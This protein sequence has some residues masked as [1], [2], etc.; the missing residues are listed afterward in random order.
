MT[1]DIRESNLNRQVV[2][3]GRSILPFL[4]IVT[5]Q[6]SALVEN[7]S[8]IRIVFLPIRSTSQSQPLDVG[9]FRNFRVHY[10]W[11]LLQHMLAMTEGTDLTASSI[12]KNVNVL[13]EIK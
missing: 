8:N 6:G 7:F 2:K 12:V 9:I 5:S 4:D 1:V 13:M 11:R 3:Q 10:H